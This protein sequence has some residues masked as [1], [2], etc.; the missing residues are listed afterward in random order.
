MPGHSSL[1][2]RPPSDHVGE[3]QRSLKALY[4]ESLP[5]L[6]CNAD[7]GLSNPLF[8][9]VPASFEQAALRL[10]IVGQQTC[11]W[12]GP[13]GGAGVEQLLACYHHFDLARRGPHSPFW[14]HAHRLQQL[15]APA[16]PPRGFVWANLVP[17]DQNK[18]RPKPD[19]LD[20]LLRLNLLRRELDILRP[21]AVVFFTGPQYDGIMQR[22]FPNVRFEAEEG[23]GQRLLSRVTHPGLPSASFRTHHPKYLQ[24]KKLEVLSAIAERVRAQSGRA[25]S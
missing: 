17:C 11:T 10:V 24:L 6:G 13:L 19:V 23:F 15:L 12:H 20:K 1:E 7:Q 4:A 25:R 22:M 3:M 8:I 21:H 2:Q 16:V 9:A 5:A 18:G 14:G